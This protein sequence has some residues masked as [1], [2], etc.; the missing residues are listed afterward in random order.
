MGGESRP[1]N[2]K[3]YPANS[4]YQHPSCNRQMKTLMDKG[5]SYFL[6]ELRDLVLL[7]L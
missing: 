2:L 3:I 4:K 7:A 1:K 6:S 5:Y